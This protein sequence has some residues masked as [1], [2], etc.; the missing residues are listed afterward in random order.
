V[1]A[2]SQEQLSSG[3]VTRSPKGRKFERLRRL[4]DAL[5][6]LLRRRMRSKKIRARQVQRRLTPEQV[7]QLVAEY[8]AGDSMLQLAKSWR[9]HRTTV[10]EHLGR[11]GIA[12]RQRGISTE[13]LGDAAR[14]YQ[15]GWSCQRLAS[16]FG[17]NAETMRQALKQAGVQLRAPWDR[18][19]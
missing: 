15:D 3:E 1:L 12:V 13:R 17:C 6:A 16:H 10:A 7:D 18:R 14:L 4:A 19:Y 2:E 11:A 8:Q 5:P 9:L